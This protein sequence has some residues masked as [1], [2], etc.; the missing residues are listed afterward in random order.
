MEP[1]L[2][3][4]KHA[5]STQ[6]ALAAMELCPEAQVGS[7]HC[8]E[9]SFAPI[10]VPLDTASLQVHF[11]MSQ[12]EITL[13][14]ALRPHSD[15]SG[16]LSLCVVRSNKLPILVSAA[17]RLYT[18]LSKRKE[19]VA[20]HTNE[21]ARLQQTMRAQ[22]S[23][24]QSAQDFAA[25]LVLEDGTSTEQEL[26]RL[27]AVQA[28][29]AARIAELEARG[30]LSLEHEEQRVVVVLRPG[31]VTAV[32]FLPAPVVWCVPRH[33]SSVR[34]ELRKSSEFFGDAFWSVGF[35]CAHLRDC[36]MRM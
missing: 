19:E 34:A 8:L 13:P 20:F 33:T 36:S 32:P 4:V 12:P 29:H 11:V 25:V 22:L 31:V 6:M 27:E 17:E 30:R 24:A 26:A 28:H 35:V 16:A 23:S 3:A 9:S 5:R 18:E 10:L 15:G 1:L 21:I 7:L 14:V 2:V